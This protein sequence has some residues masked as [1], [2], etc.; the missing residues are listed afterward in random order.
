[1]NWRLEKTVTE[2]AGAIAG[3]G[4]FAPLFIAMLRDT[5]NT[6]TI[7]YCMLSPQ[8]RH[9]FFTFEPYLAVL[10][11]LFLHPP[12]PGVTPGGAKGAIYGARI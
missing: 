10:R 9:F 6:I 2:G 8:E 5:G 7:I 12:D 1:M 4:L 3:T 11:G